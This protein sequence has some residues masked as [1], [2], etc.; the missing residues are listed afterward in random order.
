MSFPQMVL[1]KITPHC[2]N[3]SI[4]KRMVYIF[5]HDIM[6]TIN[7]SHRILSAIVPLRPLR[8]TKNNRSFI[9]C[10]GLRV[11]L[12]LFHV[13][14]RRSKPDREGR[15]KAANHKGTVKRGGIKTITKMDVFGRLCMRVCSNALVSAWTSGSPVHLEE[16]EECHG[17]GGAGERWKG[18][19]AKEK[20]N[21][22]RF[23]ACSLW[24]RLSNI[25]AGT[26]VMIQC[27]HTLAVCWITI[28]SMQF[29]EQLLVSRSLF[30]A[31]TRVV[32]FCVI[33]S[34]QKCPGL[35]SHMQTVL[36]RTN[37]SF[38]SK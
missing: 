38:L 17:D 12:S 37:I 26:R 20:K 1:I 21:V 2:Q 29:V 33:W 13:T 24:F 25:G 15:D 11:H 30:S 32:M 4:N 5:S 18:G 8:H 34:Y 16:W 9:G 35:L 6:K 28:S 19:M 3:M 36:L 22:V 10:G 14:W 7:N 27:C 31:S 23:A